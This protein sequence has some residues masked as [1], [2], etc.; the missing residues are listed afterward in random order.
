M[1]EQPLRAVGRADPD[2]PPG[3]GRGRGAPDPR[4]AGAVRLADHDRRRHVRPLQRAAAGRVQR[5]RR[6]TSAA[7]ST[8][9]CSA[10]RATPVPSCGGSP[11]TTTSATRCSAR[12]RGRTRPYYLQHRTT[13]LKVKNAH[14]L[15]LETL[16]DLGPV[17]LLLLVAGLVA[18]LVAGV[19]AR[20]QA[21]V[22]VAFGG[23]AAYLLHAGRRL[24]LADDRGHADRAHVR[25]RHAH[26]HAGAVDGRSRSR[27][28]RPRR[29]P[30]GD[31]ARRRA[32]ARRPARERR[33]RRQ[34]A[35][36]LERTT[37]SPPRAT[38]ARR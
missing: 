6:H 16:T 9:A 28:R 22:P 32:R 1:L 21:L 5:H 31:R 20:E 33:R 2:R 29:R 30:R 27:P 11:G 15:Y 8:C 23:F 10:C 19:R 3:D 7:T 12:G 36:G 17:G 13:G 34:P 24:G 37:G 38:P 18:P 35:R 14:N 25:R 4:R 26:E